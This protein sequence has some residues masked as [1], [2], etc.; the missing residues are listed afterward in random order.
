[1]DVYF[2]PESFN[3]LKAQ[4]KITASA[5]ADGLVLGHRRG[6]AFFVEKIFPT[7]RGFFSSKAKYHAIQN[8]YRDKLI[9]FF[10]F[11]PDEKKKGKILAPFACGKLYIE[12]CADTEKR[13]SI[14]PFLIDY[15]EGFFLSPLRCKKPPAKG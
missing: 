1:M 8:L 14:R 3:H 9:G 7:S 4:A 11:S 15:E 13:L 10:T 12:V 5:A 2:S 6:P